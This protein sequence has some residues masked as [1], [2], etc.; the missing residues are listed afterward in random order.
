MGKHRRDALAHPPTQHRIGQ[1]GARLVRRL[2]RIMDCHRAVARARRSAGRQPHPVSFRCALPSARR[3]RWA[4]R[5]L[6]AAT[7]RK[8]VRGHCSAAGEDI[9]HARISRSLRP[10]LL[11][12]VFCPRRR[13][14]RTAGPGSC[15]RKAA[16]KASPPSAIRDFALSFGKPRKNPPRAFGRLHPRLDIGIGPAPR[17]TH[18][19]VAHFPQHR[20]APIPAHVHHPDPEGRLDLRP[21]RVRIADQAVA[22]AATAGPPAPARRARQP[23]RS[24]RSYRTGARPCGAGPIGSAGSAR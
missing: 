20:S 5:A 3:A 8:I 9:D 24:S 6:C 7:K 19:P 13:A 18:P 14:G 16:A 17:A 1:I 21:Q 4:R 10:A 15:H 22:A 23:T 12:S 11:G 2:Y